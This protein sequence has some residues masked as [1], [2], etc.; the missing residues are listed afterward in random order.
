MAMAHILNHCGP[1]DIMRPMTMRWKIIAA[2]GMVYVLWGSTYLAI[3]FAVE[4]IPPF[5]MA[6]VR[7][8]IAGALMMAIAR[9]Q[10]TR[11][12]TRRQWRNTAIIGIF[13]LVTGNGG[14]V[15]AEQ[16][17]PSGLAAVLISAV[18][19][20]MIVWEFIFHRLHRRNIPLAMAPG[21]RWGLLLGFSGVCLLFGPRI[22]LGGVRP[23]S[24][25]CLV[26]ILA[27]IS[28][29]F[30]SLYSREVDLPDSSVQTT[31]MEMLGGG[32]VL[33]IISL[34]HGEWQALSLARVSLR[35]GYSLIYLIVFGS[36]L[37]FSAYIWLLK[38]AST[39]RAATYAYVNPVIALVL[40]AA[41]G[42]ESFSLRS[43]LAAGL[44]LSGVA[45][46]LRKPQAA[47]L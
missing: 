15:W 16:R 17:V 14:V 21:V 43:L 11:W 23:D 25:G 41:L 33:L 27:S 2:L 3:R 1:P 36:L 5:L 4:T 42:G 47:R 40:G 20:W 13:L 19:L 12:P 32:F 45:L 28:W 22:W 38:H 18:P 9:A 8:V 44:T 29:S 24:M 35:S 34:L 30:G 6:G 39:A 7:F 31:G 37:G 10:G 46:M 26:L